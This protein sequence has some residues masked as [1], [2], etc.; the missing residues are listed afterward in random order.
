MHPEGF[1][2]IDGFRGGLYFSFFDVTIR[3]K[4]CRFVL[5]LKG[6]FLGYV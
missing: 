3:E 1:F 6:K 4:M 2:E 5:F